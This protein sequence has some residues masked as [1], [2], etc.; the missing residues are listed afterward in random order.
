MAPPGV[1]PQCGVLLPPDAAHGICPKCLLGLGFDQ[2]AEDSPPALSPTEDPARRRFVPPSPLDLA[3]YFPQLEILELIGQGGMGAVYRARQKTLDRLVALKILP[4]QVGQDPAF[5]ERFTRE[6]QALARLAH[7]NIVMVFDFG[8]TNGYFFFLM[9]YVDGVNLRQSLEAGRLTPE[10]ALTIVPQVCEALQYAHDQGIVHRDIKPENVLLDKRG[11]VK[12]ADF[13]L[14]KLLGRSGGRLSLTGTDQVMGTPHYMAP[15]QMEKPLSV[16]HRADIY[17][18]GVVFYELLTGEL[19]L[20]R[21]APPSEKTNVTADLDQVVLRTLEKEP[22]RRY[23]HASDVKTAVESLGGEQGSGP[24]AVT[25]PPRA[26]RR[27]VPFTIGDVYGGLARADGILRFDGRELVLEFQVTD[28]LVGYVTSGVKTV[29]VPVSDIISLRPVTGWFGWKPALELRT[30]RLP[31]LGEVPGHE[32]GMVR[33][34]IARSDV[35]LAQQFVDAVQETMEPTAR[36][37]SA[38]PPLIKPPLP[39][40]NVPSSKV[41]NDV[42][43]P[44]VGLL[45]VGILDVVT[46][47]L[48]IVGVPALTVRQV[49]HSS[50]GFQV[51]STNQVW[52]ETVSG[53]SDGVILSSVESK[54]PPPNVSFA[55]I[56]FLLVLSMLPLAFAVVM[57][58]GAVR[59][60]RL[61]TY[62]L[63]MTAT[64]LAILPLH[65]WF[66]LGL[67]LGI[68]SLV[69]LLRRET[70]E[71]FRLQQPWGPPVVRSAHVDVLPPQVRLEKPQR[72]ASREAWE[73]LQRPGVAM[74]IGGAFSALICLPA[75]R[76]ILH[77]ED[78]PRWPLILGIL[79]V[80]AGLLQLK[81]GWH[82]LNRQSHAISRFGSTVA[83]IPWGPLWV[84]T[85]SLPPRYY[86][87]LPFAALYLHWRQ[88][89]IALT[90]LWIFDFIAGLW[91]HW[92][93]RRSD[94]R[95][96][97]DNGSSRANR[98]RDSDVDAPRP[99]QSSTVL[100]G[101]FLFLAALVGG[102]A[103][104]GWFY[105]AARYRP[106]RVHDNLVD[107][108]P[109]TQVGAP[110]EA[111][112][113]PHLPEMPF[114]HGGENPPFA[115][116]TP[117][118]PQPPKPPE[119]G[120]DHVR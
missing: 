100:V 37:K 16:D 42:H 84:L 78:V 61:K 22:D 118:A 5:A 15:E 76:A 96:A 25:A 11:R 53:T 95:A 23:Q 56:L 68:W 34:Q 92:V 14:A 7:P 19:P 18:L 28:D 85:L 30:D 59:M 49:S 99:P 50:P 44:A 10:Q 31:T 82:M 46:M 67:P 103:M 86:A 81:S 62:G 1:C 47:L 117:P 51:H 12:I 54:P 111:A 97:F 60:L 105:L 29:R 26:Q 39:H 65:P 38:A 116:A 57:I 20:G 32:K 45:L 112:D 109:S 6:A 73:R 36:E 106:P 83:M 8:Q 3:A 119:A 88:F 74:M 33:L 72:V 114:S 90:F 27:R 120:S 24:R 17:S 69:I 110:A 40:E 115:P 63:A 70:Q 75:Y 77:A 87:T 4:P 66:V 102:L 64:I 94:V 35:E 93:L 55:P 43:G 91:S 52:H 80:L 13:G 79:P 107:V 2:A 113:L 101:L 58:L 9:E 41:A 89:G 108:A 48:L 98:Y 21:F 71:A 104:L